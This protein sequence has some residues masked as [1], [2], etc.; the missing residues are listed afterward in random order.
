MVNKQCQYPMRIM[1]IKRQVQE[2]NFL[3]YLTRYETAL[4]TLFKRHKEPSIR[5]AVQ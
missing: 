4:W 2:K 5:Y 1:R 3:F